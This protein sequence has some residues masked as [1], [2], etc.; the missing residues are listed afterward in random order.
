[1]FLWATKGISPLSTTI[2]AKERERAWEWDWSVQVWYEIEWR[3]VS[4]AEI[5]NSGKRDNV[6]NVRCFALPIYIEQNFES[7]K[8]QW[9]YKIA[10]G[11]IYIYKKLSEILRI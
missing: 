11:K 9:E 6:K 8:R 1:M 4:F 3:E 5:K 10:D 2:E 7:E